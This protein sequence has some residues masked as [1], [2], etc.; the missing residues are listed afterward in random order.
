MRYI[1]VSITYK[2]QRSDSFC[3]FHT[4]LI[5]PADNLIIFCNCPA[6]NGPTAQ[7]KRPDVLRF[8]F[9][10]CLH[11]QWACLWMHSGVGRIGTF[12]LVHKIKVVDFERRLIIIIIIITTTIIIYPLT[13]RVVGAP[14][15]ISQKV[16]FIFPCCPLLFGTCRTPGLSIP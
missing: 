6:E 7:G 16:F 1:S 11:T 14:Q 5:N 13:A 2:A 3:V 12:I 8:T 9:S 4:R 10:G 15:M